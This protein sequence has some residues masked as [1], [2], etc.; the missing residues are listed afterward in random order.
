MAERYGAWTPRQGRKR[1]DELMSRY[2]S[3]LLALGLLTVPSTLLAADSTG[4][5]AKPEAPVPSQQVPGTGLIKPKVDP[6]PQMQ[7]MPPN[8]DPDPSNKDVIKPP[9]DIQPK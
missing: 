3:R 4:S 8:P 1:D 5:Q 9:A 2:A 6:D 7:K